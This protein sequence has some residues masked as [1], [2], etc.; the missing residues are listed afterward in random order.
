M[1]GWGDVSLG[2]F[3][4]WGEANVTPVTFNY[5]LAI[6]FLFALIVGVSSCFHCAVLVAVYRVYISCFHN[7]VV[8][9]CY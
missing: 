9:S 8:S 3:S 2:I 6:V 4:S 5:V 7:T 1:E